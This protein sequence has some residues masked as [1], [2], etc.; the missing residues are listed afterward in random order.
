MT[1]SLRPL[2]LIAGALLAAGLL[3]GAVWAADAPAA[4][5]VQPVAPSVSTPVAPLAPPVVTPAP[6]RPAHVAGPRSESHPTWAELNPQQQEAL[7]P[8]AG[9]WRTLS[10]AHKRKWLALSR[11]YH[12]LPAAEQARLHSRMGEWANLSP[13]QRT[14]ARMNYAA[15]QAVPAN[16]KKAKW[17][18]YQALP[19]EEKRKLATRAAAGKPVPP[20]AVNVHPG[21]APKLA[22][23][24]KPKKAESAAR[25]AVI[26]GQVDQ[27]TLLPQPGTLP[28]TP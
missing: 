7:A 28:A 12:S 25:L 20:T 3:A 15:T 24:P 17:E 19:A 13:Q 1:P 8:L 2:P 18:A 26:P 14:I 6:V 5:P 22:H 27:N 16:D 10:E 21:A 23:I 9:T 4:A 11:N